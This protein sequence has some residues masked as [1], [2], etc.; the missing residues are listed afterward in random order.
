MPESDAEEHDMI[1]GAWSKKPSSR[2]LTAIAVVLSLVGCVRG[3]GGHRES[4][5]PE[6]VVESYLN[7]ALN[8]KDISQRDELMQYTT[9]RLKEALASASE[10]TIKNAY[11]NRHYELES[12]AVIE[13]RDR[14]PRETEITF[15][16]KYKDLGVA[17]NR[18]ADTK[19]APTVQTE[20]SV[21]LLK[22]KGVWFIR[23]VVGAKT[24]IDFP[25]SQ[26]NEIRAKPGVISEPAAT[27]P[28]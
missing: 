15:R 25:V 7:T 19:S 21:A 26:E 9:G 28:N 18:P 4:M 5:A 27:E 17:E 2:C 22:E 16:L 8:M 20:N 1:Q 23:D 6:K 14:T 10:D 3:C 13:R 12:Y 24:S 11:V